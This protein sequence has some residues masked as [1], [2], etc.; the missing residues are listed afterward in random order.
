MPVSEASIGKGGE[1]TRD[2]D[3]RRSVIRWIYRSGDW[4]ELFLEIDKLVSQ[5]NTDH[6]QLAYHY[7]HSFQFT[8]YDESYQGHY[9]EHMDTFLTF[10]GPHRKISVTVQLSDPASYTGGD[11]ELTKAA[12]PPNPS[13]IRSQGTVIAFPSIAYH[14]VTP[15]TSGKRYSLV[16]WY[17]GPQ[18]R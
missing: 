16:A 13:N 12:T 2:E 9:S 10:P 18:W 11:L 8:E 7:C 3:T 1:F 6:F 15:V 4:A 5:A 17:E 14:K